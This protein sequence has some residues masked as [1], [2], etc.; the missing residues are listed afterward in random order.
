MTRLLVVIVVVTVGC[1]TNTR[2][3]LLQ[4]VLRR[5]KDEKAVVYAVIVRKGITLVARRRK[6]RTFKRALDL[7]FAFM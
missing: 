4:T 6:R 5:M 1:R 7:P 3:P 2:K